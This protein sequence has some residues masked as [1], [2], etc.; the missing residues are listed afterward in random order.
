MML[1]RYAKKSQ[2]GGLSITIV[3]MALNDGFDY[4]EQLGSDADSRPLL[5][6]LA[7]RYRHSSSSAWKTRIESGQV[8]LNDRPALP[9]T[10]LHRGQTIVWRRPPWDEP[11]AP[12]TFEVVYEDEDLLAVAKPAGLPTLPGAGFLQTTLL[13]QVRARF[14]DAAALHRLGRWTSGLVL[15]A[16]SG[17][18]RTA[19]TRQWEA[20]LVAKRYRALASGEAPSGEFTIT[21]PIGPVPHPL[22]GT[23]Q[24]SAPRGKPAA[25]HVTVLEKR[26]DGFLCDVR[27]ATGRA[28]QIRIHLA[29]AGH[30]LVGDPLYTAGGVPAA[31]SRALPGDPGYHLHAAGIL[32]RHPR[33]DRELTIE[34]EP[35]ALLRLSPPNRC[36]RGSP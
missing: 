20:R 1:S 32:V 19:L 23:V 33:T 31:L 17:A 22:L 34:C 9:G 11:D 27:I 14:P 26:P 30:P 29:A 10:V 4:R 28:H 5:G 24:A 13:Y 15:F 7:E 21:A 25:T 36:G 6:Y 18:A 2:H 35:P 12:L 8:L 16:R 3:A